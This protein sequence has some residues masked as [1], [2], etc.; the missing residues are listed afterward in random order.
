MKRKENARDGLDLLPGE[1][2][3]YGVL[4]VA[5]ADP[6]PVSLLLRRGREENLAADQVSV[7]GKLAGNGGAENRTGV[8][9]DVV[10]DGEVELGELSVTNRVEGGL[11]AVAVAVVDLNEQGRVLGA[12][13][14]TGEGDL[15]LAT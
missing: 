6:G 8:N 7:C 3:H 12:E 15:P 10:G 4:D 1:E 9:E 14:V 5:V 2:A 13:F 11:E